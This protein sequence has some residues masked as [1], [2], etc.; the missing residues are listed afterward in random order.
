[1]GEAVGVFV[2]DNVPVG[3]ALGVAP[4]V[5]VEVGVCV[6]GGVLPRSGARATATRPMQ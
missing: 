1:V 4:G 2:G 3:V 6:R 5:Q